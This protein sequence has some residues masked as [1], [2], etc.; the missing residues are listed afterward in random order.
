MG[1]AFACIRHR[2]VLELFLRNPGGS[3]RRYTNELESNKRSKSTTK[4]VKLTKSNGNMDA[5]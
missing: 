3:L 1:A 2:V 4:K 5:K